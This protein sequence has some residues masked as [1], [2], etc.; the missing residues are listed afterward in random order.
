M[1]TGKGKSKRAQQ[2]LS[3]QIAPCAQ[4]GYRFFVWEDGTVSTEEQVE[5]THPYA[6]MFSHWEQQIAEKITKHGIK[7]LEDIDICLAQGAW[8]KNEDGESFGGCVI[9][10]DGRIQLMVQVTPELLKNRPDYLAQVVCH[11]YGHGLFQRAF[12]TAYS[13]DGVP[14]YTEESVGI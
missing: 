4:R 14:D 11:E 1:G 10:D 6:K 5:A 13:D 3:A 12:F 2:T 8:E 9:N 7:P